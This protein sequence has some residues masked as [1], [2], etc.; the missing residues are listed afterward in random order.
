MVNIDSGWDIGAHRAAPHLLVSQ[1]LWLG[2]IYLVA[3]NL[4]RWN[5]LPPKDKRAIEHAASKTY[6]AMGKT[7]DESYEQML[8]QLSN[9][10][11]TTVRRLTHE[12]VS[13]F[14]TNV[15]Q[16]EVQER[17]VKEKESEGTADVRRV[18]EK[19]R[20]LVQ[21]SAKRKQ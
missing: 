1:E 14:V 12:K 7:M 10:G 4:D 16:S 2:H 8:Q 9:E 21:H 11:C 6:K 19:L 13:D 20:S 15:R 17:W 18:F 5:A 3:M